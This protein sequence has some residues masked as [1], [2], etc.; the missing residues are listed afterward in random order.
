[1]R[2]ADEQ[3]LTEQDL[4]AIR[5]RVDKALRSAGRFWQ[6]V[7]PLS[8]QHWMLG[9]ISGH[10]AKPIDS[11]EAWDLIEAI[12]K[13]MPALLEY[14]DE[15]A[16][17]IQMLETTLREIE[18]YATGHREPDAEDIGNIHAMARGALNTNGQG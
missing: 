15:K 13:D 7:R 3:K 10:V 8:A 14:I 12:P 1:M 17:R 5:E 9:T 2:M 11:E 4:V 16:E 18:E 6:R